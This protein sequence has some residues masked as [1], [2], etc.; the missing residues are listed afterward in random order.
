MNVLEVGGG[1]GG[2]T[3]WVA[4]ILDKEKTRYVFTDV[5]AM[6]V[7]R[8]RAEFASDF[9][10]MEF[11]TLDLEHDVRSASIASTRFDVIIA[12]NVIHA[13]A[14]LRATLRRLHDQLAPGGVLLMLEVAGRER[15]IDLTF[16][17]TDGWWRFSDFDLRP[18]YPLLTPPQWQQLLQSEKFVT[19]EIGNRQPHSRELLLAAQRPQ[20]SALAPGGEWI[21]LADSSGVGAALAVRLHAAGQRV[22]LVPGPSV[23]DGAPERLQHALE[24]HAADATGIVHLWGA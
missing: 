22:H 18:E 2:S 11:E 21:V 13:T 14:D 15:W 8:A 7:E 20:A 16:G 4:P 10:F 19:S 5:G 9:P 23:M 17:L 3:A 12:A 24:S 6:L 1:T